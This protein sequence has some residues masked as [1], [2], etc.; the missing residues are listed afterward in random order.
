MKQP[1]IRDVVVTAEYAA[2]AAGRT[3]F[4]GTIQCPPSNTGGITVEGD[5]GSDCELLPG[6]S[7]PFIDIDLSQIRVKGTPGDVVAI[8]G[9]A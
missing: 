3:A 7:N 2:L 4:S 8:R 5:D 9:G 1:I 6:E